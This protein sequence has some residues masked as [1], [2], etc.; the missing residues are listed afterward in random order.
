MPCLGQLFEKVG[1]GALEGGFG[2]RG[3]G[4]G[5]LGQQGEGVLFLCAAGRGGRGAAWGADVYVVVD[6]VRGG[7]LGFGLGILLGV[8]CRG[9]ASEFLLQLLV[10]LG[11]EL[12]LEVCGET[13]AEFVVEA[14]LG[15]GVGVEL[16][17]EEVFEELCDVVVDVVVGMVYGKGSGTG[18][19]S[20]PR[21]AAGRRAVGLRDGPRTDG[22]TGRVAWSEEGELQDEGEGEPVGPGLGCVR[23]GMIRVAVKLTYMMKQ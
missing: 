16:A 1:R 9:V 2:L 11:Q 15:F 22:G 3:C 13:G 18:F 23:L 21:P 20:G 10:E 7:G 17:L 4:G 19:G 6:F 8:V 12:V 5:G 14:V